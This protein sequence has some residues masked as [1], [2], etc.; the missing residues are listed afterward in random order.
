MKNKYICKK[1]NKFV[2]SRND[3][4][5]ININPKSKKISL[6]GKEFRIVCKCGIMNIIRLYGGEEMEKLLEELYLKKKKKNIFDINPNNETIINEDEL[7]CIEFIK[8][9]INTNDLI[10][11]KALLKLKVEDLKKEL[12]VINDKREKFKNALPQIHQEE[13]LGTEVWFEMY[14]RDENEKVE[15]LKGLNEEKLYEILEKE[16]EVVINIGDR[17]TYFYKKILQ[18]F[19]DDY[20]KNVAEPL[21]SI[22]EKNHIIKKEYEYIEEDEQYNKYGL[23]RL[24]E[25]RVVREG[26]I[27]DKRLNKYFEINFISSEMLK[28]LLDLKSIKKLSLKVNPY[29]LL[30]FNEICTYFTEEK[31]FGKY[32]SFANLKEILPTKLYNLKNDK[33]W[34]NIDKKNITFE[35]ILED[36]ESYED[37]IVTQVVH[38]EYFEENQEF[39]INHLDHEY[40]FYTM[41]EY[42][43]RQ[44]NINQKGNGSKRVKTFKIDNSKIPFILENRDNFLLKILNEYF[45]SKDLLEEYFQNIKN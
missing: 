30:E 22:N 26:Y 15:K 43:E 23:I 21:L 2:A 25:N 6:K 39:F 36:F 17:K 13:L 32:F 33:L 29:K 28:N 31:E 41:E 45:K 42:E 24:N 10:F 8:N 37:Y 1:C 9:K 34:I 44:N 20:V 4:G 19:Y 3:E 14:I 27:L 5:E 18:L 12:K 35:E 11:R 38:C 16:S 40:I 7:E